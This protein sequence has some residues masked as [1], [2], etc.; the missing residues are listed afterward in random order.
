MRPLSDGNRPYHVPAMLQEAVA[1]WFCSPEGIYVDGTIGGGGHTAALLERLS[2]GYVIGM[3]VDPEALAY[4]QQRFAREIQEGRLRLLRANFRDACTLLTDVMGKVQGFLLDLGLSWHQV[5]TPER[6]FTFRAVAPLDMRFSPDSPQTAEALLAAASEEELASLF[7]YYGEEP[8]AR[9]IA[10]RI[11]QRR[12]S[13][14]LRTTADLRAVVEE[15]VP[16]PHRLKS[17]ARIFQALRIAVND[18]LSALQDALQCALK[19]LA[20]YGRL[21]VLCYH[22]LEDRIVKDF[23]RQTSTS[24]VPLFRIL[25]PKPLRPSA[26]EVQ[27]NP[28]CRSARLRAAERL[29]SSLNGSS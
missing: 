6:G 18:E 23:L 14:P 29:P 10:R 27:Q 4:C 2:A 21:V 13:A 22:S 5:D 12:R 25:T 17:L 19:L 15:V 7:R 1:L 3:D 11:V 24:S 16:P 20:P 9:A 8:R 26:A 28:R